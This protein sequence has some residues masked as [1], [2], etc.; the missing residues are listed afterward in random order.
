MKSK[1]KVYRNKLLLEKMLEKEP[2]NPRWMYFYARDAKEVISEETYIDLLKK[3]INICK[4]IEEFKYFKIRALSDLINYM[5]VI[6]NY[7]EANKFISKLEALYPDL[8][9]VVYYKTLL[10]FNKY[11]FEMVRL[12]ETLYLYRKNHKEIEYGSLH[13]SYFHLD[14]LISNLLFEIGDYEKA[15]KYYRR[16]KELNY[17]NNDSFCSYL[18]E[19]INEYYE[20]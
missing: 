12:L 19:S 8:S 14:Y 17:I 3:V 20:K 13:S 15:F 6:R 7:E 11:K 5:L 1:G 9:D 18:R 4:E 16:L 2:K 10:E